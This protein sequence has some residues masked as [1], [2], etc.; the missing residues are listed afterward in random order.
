VC[1]DPEEEC[2]EAWCDGKVGALDSNGWV[3]SAHCKFKIFTREEAWSCLN[4]RWLFFWGDSNNEDTVRNLLN[5]VLGFPISDVDHFRRWFNGTLRGSS[6]EELTITK[7]FNGHHEES[8][9]LAGLSSL[10]DEGYRA[11]LAS[12]FNGTR[13]PDTVVM[14]SGL[15]DAH[16]YKTAREFAHDGVDY[17]VA[18]WSELWSRAPPAVV[19][20]TT[21]TSAGYAKDESGHARDGLPNPHKMEIYNRLFVE[22]LQQMA[23]LSSFKVVD[24]FDLTFPWHYDLNHTDGVHYGRAPS[25]TPWPWRASSGYSQATQVGHQYFVD[26]MLVHTLLNAICPLKP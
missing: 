2:D 18:F 19:Y 10:R 3:Y 26:L 5:F 6:S 17:A 16:F 24:A 7:I 23:L 8:G 14:N 21:V 20:R 1:I 11:L 12:F 13:V 9:N 4:G 15:H 22:K 25:K